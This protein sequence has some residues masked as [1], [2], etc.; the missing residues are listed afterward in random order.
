MMTRNTSFLAVTTTCFCC[1][2]QLFLRI[3]GIQSF[4]TTPPFHSIRDNKK[5]LEDFQL[6]SSSSATDKSSSS[7]SSS[8]GE[9]ILD[10]AQEPPPPRPSGSVLTDLVTNG[11]VSSSSSSAALSVTNNRNDKVEE[12][13][14]RAENIGTTTIHGKSNN[15]KDDYV[16]VTAVAVV[17]AQEEE[18]S[19]KQPP[20]P[21]TTTKIIATNNQFIKSLPDKR[22]YR[23]ITLS[24]QLTVLLT[25]DPLTDVES[26]SVHVRAGHFDDPP[27][28]A[29][30]AHFHE[31]VRCLL[32]LFSFFIFLV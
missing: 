4:A 16:D 22:H 8:S 20:P 18:I 24:N 6:W 5:R 25:S 3:G 13:N 30:L 15:V 11:V 12:N 2:T 1:I 29:G 14:C 28:R 19:T 31:H 27:N 17:V 21:P 26:A 7:T 10:L 32:L 23:A 9:A